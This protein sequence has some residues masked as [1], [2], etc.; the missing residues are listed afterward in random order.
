MA[1]VRIS[2]EI[3]GTT[4]SLEELNPLDQT[5][6]RFHN[7]SMAS[8]DRLELEKLPGFAS[9]AP[10]DRDRFVRVH[11]FAYREGQWGLE[12]LLE[13][14]TIAAGRPSV[15]D[16]LD[17]IA[18]AP[19]L[20]KDPSRGDTNEAISELARELAEPGNAINQGDRDTC[21]VAALGYVLAVT[22]PAEYARLQAD[23]QLAGTTRLAG[24]ESMSATADSFAEDRSGRSRG[25]RM[26]QSAMMQF[27][28]PGGRY[29]NKW[30][31]PV[32]SGSGWR[33]QAR[34]GFDDRRTGGLSDEEANR[35]ASAVLGR[36]FKV[37]H[38]SFF[39]TSGE[40]I[41]QKL[42]QAMA[43]SSDPVLAQIRWGDA[44]NASHFVSVTKVSG[45][46][47]FFRNPIGGS[48]MNY[49]KHIPVVGSTGQRNV[50][51]TRRVEDSDRA[52]ESMTGEE[53]ASE[54]LGIHL[55]S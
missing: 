31:E 9:M 14:G 26:L 28:H 46:R 47:V 51:P 4:C 22:N 27:A 52:I 32:N 10:T 2:S 29:H 17:R 48:W 34:S 42:R 25:E 54:V 35:V 8:V 11:G 16:A 55:P 21:G 39:G 50:A 30:K 36:R 12:A 41:L 33:G 43:A 40:E 5:C 1:L 37:H 3:D 15:L 23:L 6:I 38:K 24:G 19:R 13:K 7:Q 44:W 20:H 49:P 53:F 45:S 18:T